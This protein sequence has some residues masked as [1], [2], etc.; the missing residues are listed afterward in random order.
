VA[1]VTGPSPTVKNEKMNISYT[2]MTSQ[3]PAT[4]NV[5]DIANYHVPED[6]LFKRLRGSKG[7]WTLKIV[8]KN[9][10]PFI[11]LADKN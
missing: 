1:T 2:S 11:A 7:R 6:F 3:R 5:A 10:C 9:K 8:H 4:W